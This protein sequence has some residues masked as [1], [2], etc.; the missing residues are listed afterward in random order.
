MRNNDQDCIDNLG[1]HGHVLAEDGW[2]R[3]GT[4]GD[5]G[6]GWGWAG[7]VTAP[8]TAHGDTGHGPKTS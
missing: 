7:A 8:H 4:A 6:D 1:E 2:G 5:T 3:L